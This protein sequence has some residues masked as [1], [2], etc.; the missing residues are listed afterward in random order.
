[1][2]VSSETKKEIEKITE[3]ISVK[4]EELK[5]SFDYLHITFAQLAS[6]YKDTLWQCSTLIQDLDNII[7]D[8][9]MDE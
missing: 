7:K 1:M 4:H 9:E 8:M 2:K 3:E 5:E 6:E